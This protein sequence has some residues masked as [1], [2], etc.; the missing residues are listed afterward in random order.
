MSSAWLQQRERGSLAALRVMTW[1]A[2]SLGYRAASLLLAP[3]CLY[4][5]AFA[6]RA[7]AASRA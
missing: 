5:V 2:H 1:I 6:P 4:F 3:I 7:R